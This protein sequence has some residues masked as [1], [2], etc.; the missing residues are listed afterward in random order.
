MKER[1]GGRKKDRVCIFGESSKSGFIRNQTKSAGLST[2][3]M[4][5]DPPSP[6]NS[7]KGSLEMLGGS[8]GKVSAVQAVVQS[9][10]P[11][12]SVVARM[13]VC[14]CVRAR[15]RKWEIRER[16]RVC[17]CVCAHTDAEERER[18]S[19]KSAQSSLDRVTCPVKKKIS[20]KSAQSSL[21]R[22]TC[23]VRPRSDSLRLKVSVWY[24]W[25]V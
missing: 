6:P 20:T 21:D 2:K 11:D 3:Y 14:V 7:M 22:V 1:Q 13:C 25:G 17:M 19:T 5:C 9:F 10:V 8:Y 24:V 18:R 12:C 16:A 23:P 15:P 4:S